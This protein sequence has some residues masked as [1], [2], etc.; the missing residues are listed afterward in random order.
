MAGL[1]LFKRS[2][3]DYFRERVRMFFFTSL[4]GGHLLEAI[5]PAALKSEVG[6]NCSVS[7]VLFLGWKSDI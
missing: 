3:S 4:G 2:E 5:F 7:Y 6:E 1:L